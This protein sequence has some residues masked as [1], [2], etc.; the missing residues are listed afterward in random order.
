LHIKTVYSSGERQ[1]QRERLRKLKAKTVRREGTVDIPE[2]NR[3]ED[4]ES[5]T[6]R[7]GGPHTPHNLFDG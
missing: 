3:K 7:K 6:E 5:V 1:H 4:G 2:G